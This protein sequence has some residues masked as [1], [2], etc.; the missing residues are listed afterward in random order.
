MAAE[1]VEGPTRLHIG[2]VPNSVAADEVRALFSKV[3]QG[4][5][6]G[7]IAVE[8]QAD[9]TTGIRRGFGYVQLP[10]AADAQSAMQA[11]NGTKWKGSKLSVAPAKDN[12][13][14][15]LKQ[16]WKEDAE[17]AEALLH[18]PRPQ[19]TPIGLAKLVKQGLPPRILRIRKRPGQ[20]PLLVDPIPLEAAEG[21]GVT[22]LSAVAKKRKRPKPA[23][24]VLRAQRVSA[25]SANGGSSGDGSSADDDAADSIAEMWREAAVSVVPR[26]DLARLATLPPEVSA[27]QQ[28]EA[29]AA[30]AAPGGDDELTFVWGDE[31]GAAD[32]GDGERGSDSG[33]G[34]DVGADSGVLDSGLDGEADTADDDA[35]QDTEDE[36]SGSDAGGAGDAASPAAALHKESA[37]PA[38][39][40]VPPPL[41]KGRKPLT[42]ADVDLDHMNRRGNRKPVFRTAVDELFLESSDDEG[43]DAQARAAYDYEAE[44]AGDAAVAGLLASADAAG[45]DPTAPADAAALT[46]ALEAEAQRSMAVLATMFD[47]DQLSKPKP[48]VGASGK[49]QAL[50]S[51]GFVPQLR[52]DP[53]APAVAAVAAPPPQRAAAPAA[54]PAAAARR[55]TAAAEAAAVGRNAGTAMDGAEAQQGEVRVTAAP[56][57]SGERF[58]ARVGTLTDIFSVQDKVT[59]KLSAEEKA[60]ATGFKLSSLF[61]GDDGGGG[62]GGDGGSEAGGGG[63]GGAGEATVHTFAFGGIAEDGK[64]GDESK[65]SKQKRTALEQAEPQQRRQQRVEDKENVDVKRGSKGAAAAPL[66]PAE[67]RIW[68][69]M[70]AIRARAAQ[71]CRQGTD[72]E[73]EE[74]WLQ[75]RRNLT[76]DF[77]RKHKEALK[78]RSVAP[79]K[80]RRRGAAR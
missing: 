56:A 18:Q 12:Y 54:R 58:I 24:A 51:S 29:A 30:A 77:K 65:T 36:G 3:L 14:E 6:T 59:T 62:G 72:A 20:P 8:L 5:S 2:G 28:E 49:P 68:G 67:L 78:S 41:A 73:I 53:D 4:G 44:T 60:R 17:E 19:P 45:A 76:V 26:A 75:S 7:T 40:L 66:P 64:G 55:E 70:D 50:R 31:G 61:G 23:D 57:P 25:F 22:S 37:A 34:D 47:Q 42:A 32:G 11:F 10:T 46:V 35:F 21:G 43:A 33:L 74:R 15:R 63:S 69:D 39:A 1:A 27:A 71:F 52:F 13:L 48:A 16:Q 79:T 38:P 9:A 80:G